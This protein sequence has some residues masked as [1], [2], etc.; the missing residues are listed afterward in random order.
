MADDYPSP[1]AQGLIQ[2]LGALAGGIGRGMEQ[3]QQ[4]QY[5]Q[6]AM[7]ALEGMREHGASVD[8]QLSASLWE[9]ATGQPWPKD[10]EGNP[11]NYRLP[12]SI[13]QAMALGELRKEG[14]LGAAGI[15]ANAPAK[16]GTYKPDALT[17][18]V[19]MN[20]PGYQVMMNNYTDLKNEYDKKNGAV[21]L[22]GLVQQQMNHSMPGVSSWLAQPADNPNDPTQTPVARLAEITK[23]Q[24]LN[25][26]E[27]L[28][29]LHAFEFATQVT[30]TG[31]PPT[32]PEMIEHAYQAT[33]GLNDD[34]LLFAGKKH[35]MDSQIGSKF[36]GVAQLAGA[37][38][39]SQGAYYR[40][41]GNKFYHGMH[42]VGNGR[43]PYDETTNTPVI[44]AFGVNAPFT[45]GNPPASGG[46]G[47]AIAP[48][49]RTAPGPGS[50]Q[51]ILNAGADSIGMDRLT[52]QKV[53]NDYKTNPG[54]FANDP[55]HMK[56]LNQAKQ[57]APELGW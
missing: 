4:M 6:A 23:F 50:P 19:L 14:M 29:W 32:N 16:R 26:A 30:G 47:A 56:Y 44:P 54:P 51:G 42:R 40:D 20:A 11:L 18:R 5:Q 35:Q 9:H 33:P 12:T 28:R 38:D 10:E 37:S 48:T 13:A 27:Q 3:S 45:S 7:Q 8:P 49:A 31:R 43:V 39:P 53:W 15:R 52:A 22:K 24:Q 21:D 41:L 25:A 57:A 36:E 55:E 34:A 17:G 46:I 1:G 2:G